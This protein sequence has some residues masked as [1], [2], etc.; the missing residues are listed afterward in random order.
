MTGKNKSFLEDIF[1]LT[2]IAII[3]YG[4]YTFFFSANENI[5]TI[6]NKVTIETQLENEVNT[7]AKEDEITQTNEEI[8]INENTNEEITKDTL[9]DENKDEVTI[10]EENSPIEITN[11]NSSNNPIEKIIEVKKEEIPIIVEKKE[12]EPSVITNEKITIESFYKSIEEKIYSNIKKNLN[13][14]K[15]ISTTFTNIRVTILQDGKYEQLT[16]MGGNK[17]Y[18]KQIEASILEIFPLSVDNSIKDKFPRYFRMK[19]EN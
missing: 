5:K 10:K 3:I 11:P 18:F 16:F 4:S 13:K 8:V 12:K 19:I 9:I 17:Q 2:T 14:D 7:I 1:I 15:L 6:E